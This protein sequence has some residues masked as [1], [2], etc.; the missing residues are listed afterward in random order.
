MSRSSIISA[1]QT[2]ISDANSVTGQSDV[3]VTNA[4]NRL[5]QGYGGGSSNIVGEIDAVGNGTQYF[6]I[7]CSEE[8]D[9]VIIYASGWT[10][11]DATP[12][13]LG[14]VA[15]KNHFATGVR[16][17]DSGS[18]VGYVP[19]AMTSDGTSYPWGYAGGN[20]AVGGSYENGQFTA[21]S[22]GTGSLNWSASYSYHGI[23]IKF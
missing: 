4:T 5:I 17:N 8:P 19:A 16:C 14:Y 9:A 15:V 2:I 1:L 21:K 20:G 23:A 18:M 3:T 12:A 13:P 7:P 11:S 22:R 6:T 10:P